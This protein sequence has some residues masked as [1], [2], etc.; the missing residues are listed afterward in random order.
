MSTKSK[1]MINKFVFLEQSDIQGSVIKTDIETGPDGLYLRRKRQPAQ[2]S[3]EETANTG[4][5][6]HID[7]KNTYIRMFFP[8]FFSKSLTYKYKAKPSPPHQTTIV[9]LQWKP[10]DDNWKISI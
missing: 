5:H 6:H 3:P 7:T 10:N 8:F 4:L 9:K 2:V 1:D